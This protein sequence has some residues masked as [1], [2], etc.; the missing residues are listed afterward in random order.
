MKRILLRRGLQA[1]LPILSVGEAGFATD[2]GNLYVGSSNGN[3]LVGPIDLTGLATEEYVD[4]A[5]AAIGEG[6][7]TPAYKGFKAHYGKMF[8]DEPSINKLVIYKEAAAENIE[9]LID[10][11]TEDDYFEVRG[12]SESDFVALINIYGSSA[13][14]PLQNS[15]LMAFLEALVDN[16]ILDAND[17]L[18]SVS[19]MKTLF[20]ENINALTGTLP[21][22]S[23]YQNFEFF[24]DNFDVT[25]SDYTGGTG[26]GFEF[27]ININSETM[28]YSFAY[29][30]ELGTGYLQGDIITIPGTFF[31]A[32]TPA[33]D[34]TVTIG[35]V[36]NGQV[37]TVTAAGNAIFSVWPSN[38]INDGGAD[39]Y[40]NANY[41]TTDLSQEPGQNE[42]YYG[43]SYNNGNVVSNSSDFGG[44]GAS[45]VVVYQDSIFGLFATGISIDV[46][47]TNGNSGFDG[48]GRTEVGSLFDPSAPGFGDFV[49]SGLTITGSDEVTITN[50]SSDEDMRIRAG[51]DLYLEAY[52]DDLFIRSADDVRI[53]TNYDFS[54]GEYDNEWEFA[55]DG[56]TYLA[57]NSST[58][59]TYLS[60]PLNNTEVSLEIT[61][62]RDIYLRTG[63]Y[64]NDE[65]GGNT[66]VTFKFDD[67]GNIIIP[68]GGDILDSSGNSLLGGSVDLTGYATEDYVD[69]AIN[70]ISIPSISGLATESYVDGAISAIDIPDIGAITFEN[71]DITGNNIGQI[72][73]IVEAETA[74]NGATAANS[75]A[76]FL[77]LNVPGVL[78]VAQG[79]IIRFAGGETRTVAYEPY[80]DV[81]TTNARV[82][83]F[84]TSFQYTYPITIESPDYFVG[85]TPEV[86]II[87]GDKQWKFGTDGV[88]EVPPNGYIDI[89]GS[90]LNSRAFIV[91]GQ[92]G[93]LASTNSNVTIVSN[94]SS[95]QPKTWYFNENGTTNLP[96]TLLF[97][98]GSALNNGNTT[99][100]W[101]LAPG[102]NTVSFTVDWNNTYVMWVRGNIPNGII[103]WNAT[104]SVTNANVPVVGTQYAWNYNSG[105]TE[106]P[107]FVLDITGIPTQIIGTPGA[108]STALPAVGTNANTFV[109]TINNS[110][111]NA[112][113]ISYGYTKI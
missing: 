111:P 7:T 84:D 80:T 16:V 110:S 60:T 54:E 12:L 19:A 1:N 53:Q 24:R 94:L 38:N 9:T 99:G 65:Q 70:G 11:S 79:W 3:R 29:I 68:S 47:E 13:S 92:T 93:T 73:S 36:N 35:S 32:A 75:S 8:A 64:D 40:D 28:Q 58:N 43:I 86:N 45:Y 90:Q 42:E 17:A 14:L 6:S 18:N 23:L 83:Q 46:I 2:T 112:Q 109:F 30:N 4:E 63:G 51:D 15:D 108:I 87:A 71:N 66:S 48:N 106:A 89:S 39:Q 57:K 5:I 78:D 22:G 107:V 61:A 95:P 88:L 21:E 25:T 91:S 26:T 82:I 52:G 77:S 113:T 85:S 100:T 101:T 41:I 98:D 20:Y 34:C 44:T 74:Y 102:A 69:T 27:G 76:V 37:Q 59:D 31:N 81:V 55:S 10:T 104:V 33:N 62:G 67:E 103:A 49:V 97:P 105:T 56:T 72:G 96:G 50:E